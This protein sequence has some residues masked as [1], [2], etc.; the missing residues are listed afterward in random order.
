MKIGTTEIGESMILRPPDELDLLGYQ[1]L[2]EKIDSLLHEG[3]ARIVLDL[4]A[5]T[6]V[7]SPVVNLLISASAKAQKAGGRLALVNVQPGVKAVLEVSGTLKSLP[8]YGTA[9]DAVSA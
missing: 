8:V 6:Y 9:A 7:N 1:S 4:N 5:V 3:H 2:A